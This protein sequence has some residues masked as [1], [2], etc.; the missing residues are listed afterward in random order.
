M[1]S[2]TKE[3]TFY[4]EGD[5]RLVLDF[6]KEKIQ[7]LHAQK[8]VR[9][10]EVSLPQKNTLAVWAPLK[11]FG[12]LKKLS[13]TTAKNPDMTV[14]MI[15]PF[16]EG[17]FICALIE[18]GV[19]VHISLHDDASEWS[20][21]ITHLLNKELYCSKFSIQYI[22]KYYNESR[23]KKTK[24]QE[25]RLTLAE[26]QVL[27][28]LVNGF[29]GPEIAETLSKSVKT[30]N[31]HRQNIYNKT[32]IHSISELILMI[33]KNKNDYNEELMLKMSEQMID[34]QRPA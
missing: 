11:S 17:D 29:T 24:K 13:K 21:A 8:K 1:M 33:R 34:K 10:K 32:G 14:L 20:S 16:T 30:I 7:L 2:R 19:K 31:T 4:F 25:R 3:I 18:A 5:N 12:L 15:S 22:E 28:Y 6:V 9:V 23:K 27:S 26:K